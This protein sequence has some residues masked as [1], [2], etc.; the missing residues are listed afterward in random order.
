MARP[1]HTGNRGMEIRLAQAASLLKPLIPL[2]RIPEIAQKHSQHG[3]LALRD[4]L[5]SSK[6]VET[7]T[8]NP[9]EKANQ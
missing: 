1:R 7:I 3:R 2:A 5:K 9:R 8:S 4:I 6:M